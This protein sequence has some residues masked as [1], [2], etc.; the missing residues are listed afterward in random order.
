[1]EL[2]NFFKLLWKRRLLLIVIPLV[3]IV[4]AFFAVK[5]LPDKYISSSQI[6]TGIVDQSRQ[7][8]DTDPTRSSREQS[9]AHEF[10]NLIEIMKLKTLLNQVSYQLMLHDLTSG[11]P[12]KPESKLYQTM[13]EAARK[14]A[15]MVFKEKLSKKEPLSYYNKDENGLN[16][17]LRSMGY[18]DRS[19]SKN[20]YVI[21]DEDSDFITVGYE[22]ENP[23]L[24]AFVV[25]TLCT[26]F[27]DYYTNTVHKNETD[28]V[29][30]LAKLLDEKRKILNTKTAELQN[31]KIQNGI[32]NL[33]EQSKSI[34]DQIM[35]FNDRKQQAEKDVAS[36]TGAIRGLN[37]KFTPKERGYLESAVAKYNQAITNTQDQLHILN[38][39][40]VRSG[41]DP[42][43]KVALDSLS[44]RLTTQINQTSDKYISS[45]LTGKD[46]LVRQKIGLEV[47]R[48][49]AQNSIRAINRSLDELNAKFKSLVPFDARVKTYNYD[50]DIASKEYLDVL[51]KY[52][53]TNLQSTFSIK[54]RQVEPAM[55]ETAEPSKKMLLTVV[56]GVL[57]FVICVVVLFIGWFFDDTIKEPNDLV[58]RTHL[59]L[60]SHLN[61]V[62]GALDLRKLW[63]VENRDRMRLFKEL[64]R[65]LRFEIDQELRGEKILAITSL[66]NHEG[67]SVVGISL[68][69]SYAMINKKVLLIDGNFDHPTITEVA[70]PKTYL[71]DYFKN[72]PDNY[73]SLNN[74]TNVI[75][76]H[77]GDVTL[78]ELSDENHIRSRFNE[79]KMKYDMIIIETPPLSTLNKSKEWILFANKVIAIFETNKGIT[80]SQ[81]D[82]IDYLRNL[83][84]KF[85]GWV[86]N[87]T[88]PAAE[89]F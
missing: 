88:D 56:A 75:G 58:K 20:L 40:Y 66:V 34:F 24:S 16:G 12:F 78:L 31:Y 46:E 59:P 69:Y 55:P 83:N 26:E 50:I 15:I 28:A 64:T 5:N 62:E 57:A 9:I 22:S 18:D 39:R 23:Q 1:M 89:K 65:S 36:Y 49:M 45:P 30:Y 71:E 27:I 42:K 32:L 33:D 8:L 54:L 11:Y 52:N 86:L 51:N 14:H 19:L 80:K 4:V 6:A 70:Q 76:N 72:N 60:L 81:K 35:V 67:K 73:A 17:L 48:D 7:L 38:D 63:D 25:N 10:S 82:N 74:T 13:N 21:R 37:N 77:G 29:N 47:N 44:N 87:K 84:N 79:L 41:F 3:T 68:A 61:M 53:Q 2:G 85:A 43:L